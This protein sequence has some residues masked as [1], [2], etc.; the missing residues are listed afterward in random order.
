M[1]AVFCES[2]ARKPRPDHPGRITPAGSPG[3]DH[4]GRITRAVT[5]L[6]FRHPARRA[7]RQKTSKNDFETMMKEIPDNTAGAI[8]LTGHLRA[9]RPGESIRNAG[10]FIVA[11]GM[12]TPVVLATIKKK[13]LSERVGSRAVHRSLSRNRSLFCA[14]VD[15][16][17]SRHERHTPD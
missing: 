13:R 17:R 9:K 1:V 8:V 14:S 6:W 16:Q 15:H 2:P 7:S 5:R 12:L 3:P 10:T 4:P 11:Q